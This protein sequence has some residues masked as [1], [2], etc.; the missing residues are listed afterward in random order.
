MRHPNRGLLIGLVCASV[1]FVVG[2]FVTQTNN[3]KRP[4]GPDQARSPDRAASSELINSG[5]IY[6]DKSQL[7]LAGIILASRYTGEIRDPGSLDE[8]RAA[9]Q[10][11]SRGALEALQT[12]LASFEQSNRPPD[13]AIAR[14]LN[15]IGTLLTYEGRLD[16]AIAATRKSL[17]IG[18]SVGMAREEMANLQA[19]LGILAFRQ[20]EVDNC[21][22]CV[23]PSSCILPISRAAVHIKP[24]GSRQAIKEFTEYLDQAP[25]DL[26]VRW[27]LN[28]SYM[29]LGQ[30]PEKVPPE[31]LVPL[32]T[33][34]SKVDVGHFDNVAPGAGLLSRG[35]NLAGGSV[36]DDFTGDGL[37]DLFFTS[38]DTDRGASFFVN[39]GDGRFEDRS[40]DANLGDQIYALNVVR[41]DFDNDGHLDV[42]LLR[43]GWEQPMRMSLLR[44]TGDSRFEDVTLTSGLG[45]PITTETA[46]W[47]DYDNDGLV[48][49][50]V[51][52]E[53]RPP[54]PDGG[55]ALLEPR[56]RCRLYHNDG[57]GK[58]TDVA[59][60]LGVAEEECTK[61]TA[62]G[63]FDGDGRLDLF[64]SNMNAPCR[65]Y[66]NEPDGTFRDVAPELGV[67]GPTHGFESHAFACWF[68]DYDNDGRLDL[69]VND[70]TSTFA[71]FVAL[72][73]KIPVEQRS[74]PRL[75][76]NLG[77][78][79]FRD[80][81][82]DVG[83]DRDMMP[84]GCNF[85]DIDNDGYLDLYFGTGRMAL[86][87]LVPNLMFKSDGGRK[88]LD[89]TTSS[90]TGHL[91]KGHGISFADWNG[92]G[93]L[94]IFVVA[95]G[96]VPGDR[97]YNLLFQNPGHGNHWLKVK[98]VGTK[99][100]R[101]ALGAQIKA[102]VKRPDGESRTIYRTIGNNS[103]FG[104][105][106]LVETIGLLDATRV[107]ELQVSWP[108]SGTTQTFVDIPAD[109][110]IEITEGIDSW[111]EIPQQK[112]IPAKR[113]QGGVACP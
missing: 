109:Q 31:Y 32:N 82:I 80:V 94:D 29:T 34:D 17:E 54:V 108:T 101:A 21:I 87:A 63:D 70:Y 74:R 51:G 77:T 26:R 35:P 93:S 78:D 67:T 73:L 85:G 62:W 24:A 57:N 22:G 30:Y 6:I 111:K 46:A 41:A 14:L 113:D 81:T 20:G 1:V 50:F 49:L 7:A 9:I 11:R 72:E 98:L 95:G 3:V 2:I 92:D 86:E 18:R 97:A 84:M 99:T 88:F 5:K 39:R 44:N 76:R 60:K 28:L 43:G 19:V 27:L 33:F 110:S 96:A 75:Y 23:G 90:G 4:E 103:S 100:N 56:N 104:G 106:T 16:E 38:L 42:L 58:F 8:L 10:Q 61:G 91:Q 71:E 65:L 13:L 89:V 36:F 48:D 83:L 45:E 59:M 79:G 64:V 55:A 102:V 69:Y 105:N 15:Q 66:H 40:N 25:G 52:G 53:Y 37:P 47:G 12:E 107:A 68:W 112:A